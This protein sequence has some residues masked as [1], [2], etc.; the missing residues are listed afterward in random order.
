MG[1]K[2]C[3]ADPQVV[4]EWSAQPVAEVTTISSISCGG[5]R[6]LAVS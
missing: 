3:K 4:L 5:R 1:S 6:P 2:V